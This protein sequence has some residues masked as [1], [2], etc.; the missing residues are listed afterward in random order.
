[1]LAAAFLVHGVAVTIGHFLGATLPAPPLAFASAIAF[2]IFAVWAWRE[3]AARVW[4]GSSLLFLMFG[5]WM[6]FDSAL[7]WR[8]VAIAVIAS[9]N[10]AAAPSRSYDRRGVAGHRLRCRQDLLLTSPW[11]TG[12]PSGIS[13]GH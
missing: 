12:A 11:P 6:L 10:S 5:L 9:A 13:L 8:S 3:G 2:L 4:I 1:M 7:G